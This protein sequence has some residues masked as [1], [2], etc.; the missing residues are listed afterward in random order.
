[1][2]ILLTNDDGIHAPGLRLMRLALLE[3]GHRV[4]V[5]A[6]AQEQSAMSRALT[7]RLPLLNARLEEPGFSGTA[8]YGTP[9]DCVKLGLV[10]LLTE[11]P[12]LVLSGMNAGGNVG[13]DLAYSGTVAAAAEGAGL[14]L[15]SLAVSHNS[16][17]LRH[18]A[19]Y[20][21]FAAKLITRLPWT[22]LPTGD[23]L[24]LNLPA[25]PFQ[26]CKG[27]A[28]CPQS[29]APWRDRYMEQ[30]DPRGRPCWWLDGDIPLEATAPGDDKDMLEQGW[31]TLT[32]LRF[33]FT[34]KHALDM[35]RARLN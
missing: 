1:M 3:A 35:L 23:M 6:P 27:L 12:D 25:C 13:P 14:G 30:T 15:P 34:D 21:A 20:A 5:I 18:G 11:K 17:E 10:R 19:A 16:R 33:E 28:V 31:A 26:D 8:V 7:V 4:E 9:A 32:P 22:E 29:R 24:N 2:F